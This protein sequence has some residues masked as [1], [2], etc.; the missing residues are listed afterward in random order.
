MH[1]QVM[2]AR[3]C[4]IAVRTPDEARDAWKATQEMRRHGCHKR[5]SYGGRMLAK[6]PEFHGKF[7]R[8][9]DPNYI[10]NGW[11]DRFKCALAGK[12]E[13]DITVISPQQWQAV[14]SQRRTR[15]GL[16]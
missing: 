12:M 6:L 5:D 7:M 11:G 2:D 4:V 1:H 8:I 13:F 15:R 3:R 16:Q 9:V 10:E 14:T